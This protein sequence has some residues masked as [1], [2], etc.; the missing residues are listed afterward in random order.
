MVFRQFFHGKP[1]AMKCTYLGEFEDP[2]NERKSV[3]KAVDYL[4]KNI[5]ELRIPSAIVGPGVIVPVA[6][7]RQQDQEKDENGK[8]IAKNYN[9]YIYPLYDCNLYEFHEKYHDQ[10][11]DSILSDI[12]YQCLTRNGSEMNKYYYKTR[13][14][15]FNWV[16]EL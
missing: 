2:E 5:S 9:V 7:I 11:R 14:Y 12:F 15:S 1:M 3:N 16:F 4:E 6:F 8:W 13:L 10:F